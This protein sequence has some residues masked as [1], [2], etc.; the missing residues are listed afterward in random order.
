[1]SGPETPQAIRSI[2]ARTDASI[3]EA[4]E[5]TRPRGDL[6]SS[7]V[8]LARAAERRRGT[9]LDL[10]E[11]TDTIALAIRKELRSGDRVTIKLSD[12]LPVTAPP[13]TYYAARA[14]Q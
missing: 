5:S 3:K 6:A 14:R 8:A 2:K 10:I 9:R 13:V 7:I 11:A 12:P 4:S 1:M